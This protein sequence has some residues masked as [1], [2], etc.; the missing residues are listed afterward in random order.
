MKFVRKPWFIPILLAIV[1]LVVGNIYTNR[2]LSKDEPLPEQEVR[3]QLESMYG[4]QVGPLKQNGS[5]YEAEISREGGIYRAEIDAVTGKVLALIQTKE[6]SPLA[7]DTEKEAAS[8]PDQDPVQGTTGSGQ[9]PAT[10]KPEEKPA[11]GTSRGS[12]AEAPKTPA[13]AT[14]QQSA[15]VPKPEKQTVLISE[16]QAGQIALGQLNRGVLA[17]VDDVEYVKST[18]GGYYLVEIEIDTD[19]E[20]D[21]VTY[22]IHAISGKI[23]SVTWDE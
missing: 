14:P 21:E 4:A 2:I 6:T 16:T 15:P 11:A 22:Q 12:Q 1:I 19:D 3:T 5:V 8:P 10:Q 18:D 7:T 13:P 20:L 17:E 9:D 23:M